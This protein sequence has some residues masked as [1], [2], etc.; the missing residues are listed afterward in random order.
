MVSSCEA[1]CSPEHMKNWVI[2]RGRTGGSLSRATRGTVATAT[3]NATAKL[4]TAHPSST[5]R[6]Y[7]L[8]VTRVKAHNLV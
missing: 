8:S 7:N 5:G 3:V 4:R 6:P 1:T 2:E